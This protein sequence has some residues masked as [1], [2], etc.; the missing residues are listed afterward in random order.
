M[1][2]LLS[3]HYLPC[4]EYF[5]CFIKYDKIY[6]EAC[7]NYTKQSYRNRCMIKASQKIDTLSVPICK[8]SSHIP[9][10]EVRIDYS[11]AW[12][13]DHWRGIQTAYGKSPFF[14]HYADLFHDIFHKAP[15]HLFDL[16]FELLTLC[17]DLL[18]IDAAMSLTVDYQQ[19]PVKEVIDYR[20]SIHPKNSHLNNDILRPCIYPQVFGSNFAE[21]LSIIDLLFCEG[22]NARHI[23]NQSTSQ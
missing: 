20:K 17:L 7:E 12:I 4:I 1:P 23:L 22:P 3:L 19:Y 11:Q 14:E 6:I 15:P 18:Q 21:N 8:D 9:I 10:K 16:N 5:A 2:A 13:K